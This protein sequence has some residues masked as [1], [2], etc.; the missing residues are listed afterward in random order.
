MKEYLYYK[1]LQ[2]NEKDRL[3]TY[4]GIH[5]IPHYIWSCTQKDSPFFNC[6]LLAA[7]QPGST[8]LSGA[9]YDYMDMLYYHTL[10]LQVCQLW[11]KANFCS[12]K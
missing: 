12:R 3:V 7:L 6:V 5:G 8:G 1:D 2:P 10:G 4:R 11:D 9:E